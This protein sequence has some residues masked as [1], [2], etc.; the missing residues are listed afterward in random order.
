MMRFERQSKHDFPAVKW[1]CGPFQGFRSRF[2]RCS[3]GFVPF[4]RF[5]G[6]APSRERMRIECLDIEIFE[7]LPNVEIPSEGDYS[8]S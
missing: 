6:E 7:G 3:G 5:P 2:L 1:V 4:A 8:S